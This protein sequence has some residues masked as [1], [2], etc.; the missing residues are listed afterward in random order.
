MF[1]IR[2]ARL[3]SICYVS[4]KF[5]EDKLEIY[6]NFRGNPPLSGVSL[7]PFCHVKR[8]VVKSQIELQL[9]KLAS[10]SGIYI[11]PMNFTTC[12]YSDLFNR[13]AYVIYMVREDV[14][15]LQ[16]TSM[17]S[18]HRVISLQFFQFQISQ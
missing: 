10:L 15:V 8:G 11:Q 12:T 16:I 3:H 6:E 9:L 13:M 7:L 17:Y 4:G 1:D 2:L 18:Y 5:R 14:D